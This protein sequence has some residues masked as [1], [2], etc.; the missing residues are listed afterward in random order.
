MAVVAPNCPF[1]LQAKRTT[2]FLSV[3]TALHDT[4][5]AVPLFQVLIQLSDLPVC[6]KFECLHIAV[7]CPV[8]N[9]YLQENQSNSSLRG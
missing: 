2:D 6:V 5:P 8:N 7:F 1:T 3:L 4:L 9:H